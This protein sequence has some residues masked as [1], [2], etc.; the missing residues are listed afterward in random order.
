[1]EVF[2]LVVSIASGVGTIAG[3]VGIIVR[4]GRDKG[5]ADAEMRELRKDV[6]HNAKDINALGTKVN[7]IQLETAVQL[8]TLS[9]DM[10]WI[11]STLEDIKS[12]IDR[13]A[14]NA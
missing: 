3:V 7:N 11:K 13:G 5:E 14:R 10:G 4:M 1:M 8:R 2:T 9:G 6:D 12:K